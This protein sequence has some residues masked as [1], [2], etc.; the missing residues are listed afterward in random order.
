MLPD[1]AVSVAG[2]SDEAINLKRSAFHT[3]SGFLANL[4]DVFWLVF[5]SN[6]VNLKLLS[7]SSI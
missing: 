7:G 5:S 2:T 3:K 6:F 1:G 4:K